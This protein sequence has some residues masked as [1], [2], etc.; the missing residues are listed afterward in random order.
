MRRMNVKKHKIFESGSTGSHMS[1]RKFIASTGLVAAGGILT[2][3]AIAS[4]SRET[5]TASTTPPPL[6]WPWVKLDPQ[7]AGERAF[8]NYH[9]KGG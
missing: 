8:R 1:R 5:E 7:E 6:P 9:E 3:G 2:S 4:V